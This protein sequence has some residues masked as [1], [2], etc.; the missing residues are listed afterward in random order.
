MDIKLE[1]PAE[2]LNAL[3]ALAKNGLLTTL[4]LRPSPDVQTKL[5][6]SGLE[7]LD[8]DKREGYRVRLV[9]DDLANRLQIVE[10]LMAMA[11]QEA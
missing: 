5:D 1:S 11:F 8:Y 4:R 3:R 9:A 2:R 7:T 10:E 6:E